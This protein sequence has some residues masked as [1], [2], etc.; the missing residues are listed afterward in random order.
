MLA[1]WQVSRILGYLTAARQGLSD[2]EIMDL[3]SCDEEVLNE[4][5]VYNTPPGRTDLFVESF[6]IEV[7]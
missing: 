4:I 2:S 5:F 6:A 7:L 1:I 3:L